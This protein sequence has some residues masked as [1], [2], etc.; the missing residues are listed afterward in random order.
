MYTKVINIY[1]YKNILKMESLD[2]INIIDK[3]D[4]TDMNVSKDKSKNNMNQFMNLNNKINTIVSKINEISL[5]NTDTTKSQI[6]KEADACFE[7][8]GIDKDNICPHGLKF[9]QCMPC[10]H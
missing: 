4:S 6:I 7:V 8:L 3:R 9:F 5:K 1:T 10:S 2:I